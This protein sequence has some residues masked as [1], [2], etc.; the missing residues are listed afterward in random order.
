MVTSEASPYVK[1]G[2]L[3]DVLGALPAALVERGEEV[4][5]VLPRY[6]M[7]EIPAVD[8]IWHAMPLWVG[9]HA[10]TAAIDL[11]VSDGVRYYFVDCPPLFDRSGIYGDHSGQFEGEY[12]DNHLRF[13]LLN[14]AALEIARHIF[15]TDI[16]HC[17]DW[18]AGLLA[19]YLRA[20]EGDPTFFGVKTILTIHNLAYQGI[21]R[22]SALGDLGLDRSLFHPG[23]LEFYGNVSFLK[24]GIVWSDKITTVSPTYA[25]EIQTPEYG[26]GL[27]GV[28]RSR[29]D[30]VAGILNGVDYREWDPRYDPHLA[31]PYWLDNLAGKAACKRA[32]LQEMF[33]DLVQDKIGLRDDL[34][35]ADSALFNSLPEDSIPV[36]KHDSD[37]VETRPL[38]GIV[39]RLAAQKGFDMFLEIATE[40]ME[41]GVAFAVLG[42][43]DAA[44]ENAFRGL[45]QQ[46][47]DRFG[48]RIG[49]DN[50]LAH[51]IEAGADMFL[52]PS[53]YE[54]SGLNQMYSLRYG[55]VPIVRATGGL[56]DTIDGSIALGDPINGPTGFKFHGL[57]P[58]ALL[59]T[60]RTALKEWRNRDAWA[61][62]MRR[63]MAKDF[64]WGASA[65]KYQELYRGLLRA[66]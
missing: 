21:F 57:T 12:P 8:R 23:G 64:S 27:D 6:R 18:Q 7:A 19:P 43:G 55:T 58:E 30:K 32:L 44:L 17:H 51:R 39:S 16:F 46:W 53:R 20:L 3:G 42:S 63:G 34:K 49:Y 31:A 13:G 25:R 9:S 4:A 48:V 2:G 26:A 11:L 45:A 29:A 50:A 35:P 40:V 52:M 61:G 41:E 66:R 36:S 33:P 1:T 60:I 62:R 24:A 5:V 65:A 59:E 54:P 14:R 37:G 10:F 47:P 28:L 38:I 22:A 15:K 56:E